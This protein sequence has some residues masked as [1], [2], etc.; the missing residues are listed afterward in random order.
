[1]ST[2]A[3]RAALAELAK[4]E[5]HYRLKFQTAPTADHLD[6][7]RAWDRMRKAGDAARA[8]LA[9]REAQPQSLL[10]K[11]VRNIREISA[12]I[13]GGCY[14]PPGQCD[15]PVVMGQQTPCL[16]RNDASKQ[17]AKPDAW[18]V[19][20]EDGL[21][22]IACA[23]PEAAHEHINDALQEH[24]IQEAALWTVRPLY[25]SPQE[26][27][28]VH[29]LSDDDVWNSQ[30]IMSINGAR[31]GLTMPVLMD[32]VRAI[33]RLITERAAKEQGS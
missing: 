33:E 11:P 9:Q 17:G 25:A 2:E 4:A 24:D 26:A 22:V 8:A 3:L 14:C 7:G 12:A 30:E 6:V 23:W 29:P 32:L 5:A 15:A 28:P 16:R 31:A 18:V 19:F 21:P 10:R 20:D 13:P 27:Q 1:M